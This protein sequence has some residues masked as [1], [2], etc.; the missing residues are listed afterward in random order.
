MYHSVFNCTV[1]DGVCYKSFNFISSRSSSR[2]SLGHDADRRNSIDERPRDVERR[3]S[4]ESETARHHSRSRSRSPVCNGPTEVNHKGDSALNDSHK[5]NDIKVKQERKDSLPDDR[6][7]SRDSLRNDLKLDSRND[8]HSR[9]EPYPSSLIGAGSL[10]DRARMPNPL[11]PYIM[12]ME[13]PPQPASLW[14]PFG[15]GDLNRARLEMDRLEL[16]R[17][18][19]LRYAGPAQLSSLALEQ[20]RFREQQ[21]ML[22]RERD[23]DLIGLERDR[24]ASLAA[25][26]E[27]E[28]SRIPPLRPVDPFFGQPPGMYLPR[29]NSSPLLNHNSHSNHNSNSGSK[30]NSPSSSMGIPPPLIPSTANIRDSPNSSKAKPCSPLIHKSQEA[31]ASKDKAE[32]STN[33]HDSD[34]QSR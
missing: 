11:S 15:M 2:N 3:E 28:R 33:G 23:R 30:N 29:T 27:F 9:T 5:S 24:V 17:E 18:K 6:D 25:A 22:R 31:T 13:R 21:E 26:A 7:R 19:F 34:P 20:D 16:D 10:L 12:G 4:R 1:A 8:I 14:H 32:A